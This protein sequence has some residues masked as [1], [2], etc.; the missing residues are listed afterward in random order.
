MIPMPELGRRQFAAGL[1][2]LAPSFALAQTPGTG[3]G[4]VP[5]RKIPSL[6]VVWLADD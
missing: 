2:L 4:P 3:G 5:W 6:T 1:A